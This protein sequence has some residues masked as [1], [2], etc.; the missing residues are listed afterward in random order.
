MAHRFGARRSAWFA[1]HQHVVTFALQRLGE[2]AD[3]R[4]FPSAFPA[5]KRNEQ[6]RTG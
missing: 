4:G 2:A 3:L 5:F 1:R 6:S